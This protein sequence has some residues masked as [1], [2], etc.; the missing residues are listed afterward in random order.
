MSLRADCLKSSAQSLEQIINIGVF[1]QSVPKAATRH[2][3][4]Q[5]EIYLFVEN[6]KRMRPGVSHHVV[7][8][9]ATNVVMVDSD[10]KSNFIVHTGPAMT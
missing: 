10:T 8:A 9:F 6:L 4:K 7:M 1:T 3:I 2:R 5:R